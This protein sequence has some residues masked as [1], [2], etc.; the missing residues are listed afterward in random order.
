M[1]PKSELFPSLA[2]VCVVLLTVAVFLVYVNQPIQASSNSN[3][4]GDPCSASTSASAIVVSNQSCSSAQFPSD[5]YRNATLDS[6]YVQT[7]IKTAYEYFLTSIETSS[8]NSSITHAIL[9]VTGL[10]SVEGTWS[11]GYSLSYTHNVLLNIT[12]DQNGASSFS[13]GGLQATNLANRSSTISFTSQEKPVIQLAIS[14]STVL[15]IMCGTPYY[16]ASVTTVSSTN[17]NGDY[18]VRL[19]QVNGTLEVDAYV[20]PEVTHVVGIQSSDCN[21]DG[22]CSTTLT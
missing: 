3:D 5:A 2:I 19:Y 20:N 6:A 4:G 17:Y 10:Q 9:N 14:N 13:F 22:F 11:G 18:S 15:L 1:R 21:A 12:V 8:I 7:Y 16:I